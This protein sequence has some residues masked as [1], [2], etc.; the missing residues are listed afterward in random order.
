MRHL[1]GVR[2]KGKDVRVSHSPLS[3]FITSSSNRLLIHTS[4]RGGFF[5]R[6]TQ[7]RRKQTPAMTNGFICL[8]A[9]FPAIFYQW[10]PEGSTHLHAQSS[11]TQ[12]HRRS[13]SSQL[14][15]L[16]CSKNQHT[17]SVSMTPP[18]LLYLTEGRRASTSSRVAC[19]S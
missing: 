19:S 16:T 3:H 8:R 14:A 2:Q 7:K 1:E 17:A 10:L 15:S 9:Q 12:G 5:D 4:T 13:R 11:D 18:R 6:P